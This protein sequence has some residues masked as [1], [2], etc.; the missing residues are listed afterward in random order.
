MNVKD[1]LRLGVP[2][3]EDTWRATDFVAQYIL[4][5]GDTSKLEDEIK[6]IV[7]NPNVFSEDAVRKGLR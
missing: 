3:G 6:A 5:G 1:F 4:R 2:L 7:A